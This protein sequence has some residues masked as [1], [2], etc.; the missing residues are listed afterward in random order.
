MKFQFKLVVVL[1]LVLAFGASAL[2][3]TPVPVVVISPN[4]DDPAGIFLSSD[5]CGFLE[6]DSLV[7]KNL[8]GQGQVQLEKISNQACADENGYFYKNDSQLIQHGYNSQA[9]YSRIAGVDAGKDLTMNFTWSNNPRNYVNV[10]LTTGA[11]SGFAQLEGMPDGTLDNETWVNFDWTCDLAICN[12]A[13]YDTWRVHTDAS[14]GEVAGLA[15]NDRYGFISFGNLDQELAPRQ[16]DVYIDFFANDIIDDDG[17]MDEPNHVNFTSAPLADGYEMWRV[18]MQL[19]DRFTGDPIP[20]A[21]ATDITIGITE[22]NDSKIYLDQVLRTGANDAVIKESNH[23]S[24]PECTNAN[25]ACELVE[26]DGSSSFNYF[27]SSGGPTSNNLGLPNEAGTLIENYTDRDHCNSFYVDNPWDEICGDGLSLGTKSAVFYDRDSERNKFVISTVDV[28]LDLNEAV[29]SNRDFVLFVG[30]DEYTT[31]SDYVFDFSYDPPENKENLSFRPF[32]RIEKIAVATCLE[33]GTGEPSCEQLTVPNQ[34]NPFEMQLV[35][36]IT[37]AG[38]SPAWMA[39]TGYNVRSGY[40]LYTR[41]DADSDQDPQNQFNEHL[42]ITNPNFSV[43]ED[44]LEPEPAFGIDAPGGLPFYKATRAVATSEGTTSYN[45][46][47]VYERLLTAPGEPPNN[48]LTK[49]TVEQYV[50]DPLDSN[51]FFPG[52]K[53]C[54]FVSYLPLEDKHAE[55]KDMEVIGAV[56]STSDVR[57]FFT[58]SPGLSILGSADSQLLRNNIYSQVLRYTVGEDAGECTI[59]S[60]FNPTNVSDAVTKFGGRLIYCEGDV[61]INGSDAFSNSTVV[62]LGGNIYLNGNLTG[63]TAGL[64]SL[65]DENGNGGYMYVHPSVTDIHAQIFLDGSLHSYDGDSTPTGRPSWDSDKKRIEI[66]KNTLYLLGSLTSRNTVGGVDGTAP[67]AL[68]DG[69][70][71][72]NKANA[73]E[74]DLNRLRRTRL[75]YDVDVVTGLLDT[76]TEVL[77]EDDTQFSSYSI[78][79]ENYA[80][81]V[82]EGEAPVELPIF[83]SR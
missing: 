33:E 51:R 54:Y 19:F 2:A 14:T 39:A 38:I 76:S 50:C 5:L 55:A 60:N 29:V 11:W 58:D 4:T 56:K 8:Q 31:D 82:I 66:L 80:P 23:P 64:I 44:Y 34:D 12:Q 46:P 42:A 16:V 67:F 26:A 21:A 43:V 36:D 74:D 25:Q 57:S 63:G 68:G 1:T 28:H 52:A 6:G 3:F 70:T 13:Y 65:K 41:V 69:T 77:C 24:I 9:I 53:S 47:L 18:R 45:L 73:R 37:Y 78:E 10:D 72:N 15:W 81:F 35:W 83:N 61:I 75:C 32:N 27:V 20:T 30:E 49:P 48:V 62:A 59:D 7:H 40:T 71:S 22:K 79:N 17:V